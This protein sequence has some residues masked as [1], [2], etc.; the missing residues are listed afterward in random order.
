MQKLSRKEIDSLGEYVKIYKAKGLA[1]INITADGIKSPI[2]KFLKEEELNGIVERMQAK[3]GDIIFIVADASNVVYDSLGQLRL[4]VGRRFELIDKNK[5]NFLW[6][7]E[8]PL[9]D[10][11]EEEKRYVAKHHPFTSPMDE[12]IPMLDTNPSEVRAK[13]YD[14]VLNGYEIGGGSIRIHNQQ[15]QEKMFG[16]LGFSHEAGMAKVWILT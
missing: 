10:Y 1:W 12:D 6:V 15:L 8:F 13:A 14:M 9:L 16:L 2:A 3:V 7:T 4:E 11:D 5:F